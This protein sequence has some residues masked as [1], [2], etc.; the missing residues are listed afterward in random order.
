MGVPMP[1]ESTAMSVQV[2][3]AESTPMEVIVEPPVVPRS[4][5]SIDTTMLRPQRPF[6]S[7]NTGDCSPLPVL[8]YHPVSAR[9][10]STRRTGEREQGPDTARDTDDTQSATLS[11]LFSNAFT[12]SGLIAPPPSYATSQV[13]TPSVLACPMPNTNADIIPTS[14]T[15]FSTLF[16]NGIANVSKTLKNNSFMASTFASCFRERLTELEQ[17]HLDANG[18]LNAFT[19]EDYIKYAQTQ[20]AS[21]PFTSS[22]DESA[23]QCADT[24]HHIPSDRYSSLQMDE[25]L[26]EKAKNMFHLDKSLVSMDMNALDKLIQSLNQIAPV[27]R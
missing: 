16:P 27:G 22:Y 24:V 1:T 13:A 8:D 20:F 19:V 2:P 5:L 21:Q 26:L 18:D 15:P 9:P 4:G 11:D 6:P 17:D 14:Y 23:L 12:T 25:Q 7:M 3:V 10:N